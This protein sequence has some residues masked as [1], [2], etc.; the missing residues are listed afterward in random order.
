MQARNPVCDFL[1]ALFVEMIVVEEQVGRRPFLLHLPEE[2]VNHDIVGGGEGKDALLNTRGRCVR[3][4]LEAEREEEDLEFRSVALDLVPEQAHFLEEETKGVL[5][6]RRARLLEEVFHRAYL[7]TRSTHGQTHGGRVLEQNG[8]ETRWLRQVDLEFGEIVETDREDHVVRLVLSSDPLVGNPLLAGGP[9]REGHV[10]D[11]PREVA[12]L[13][14]SLEHLREG[15]L[16]LDAVAEGHA[17]AQDRDSER[18]EPVRLSIG[19]VASRRP[20]TFVSSLG[21]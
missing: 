11:F 9:P 20:S 18:E 7:A 17:V 5:D 6:L 2:V 1:V 8:Q 13:E 14:L 15:L 10:E 3:L 4:E 16:R 21:G 19:R 12:L